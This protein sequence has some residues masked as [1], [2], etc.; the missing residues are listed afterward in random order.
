MKFAEQKRRDGL[1]DLII[2][3]RNEVGGV[4]RMEVLSNA[5]EFIRKT[6][7]GQ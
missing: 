5:V 4:S 2:D 7:S 3:L 1:K 6:K